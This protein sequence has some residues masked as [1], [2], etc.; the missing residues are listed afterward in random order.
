MTSSR[1]RRSRW[2]TSG[3]QKWVSSDEHRS[4]S[5]S[6]NAGL[7]RSGWHL[8]RAFTVP[9]DGNYQFS[10][11]GSSFDTVLAVHAT[12]AASNAECNNDFGGQTTS[13]V[14]VNGLNAREVI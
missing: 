4:S 2:I 12:S 3:E 7:F 10:T 13:Q 14:T 6:E 11:A 5:G 1:V 9:A 8:F